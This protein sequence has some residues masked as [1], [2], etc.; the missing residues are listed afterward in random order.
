MK[1]IILSIVILIVS[2]G[3]SQ[4]AEIKEKFID[5]FTLR[6]SFQSKNDKAEPALITYTKPKDKEASWLLNAAIGYDLL[7]KTELILIINPYFEYHKNTLVDKEQ[8]NW[9]TGIS[10][11]WQ[12]IRDFSKYNWSPIIISSVKYNEDKIKNLKSFQGNIYFTPIFKGKDLNPS[13]FWL[14]NTTVNFGSILQFVYSPYVGFENEN[15]IKNSSAN[16]VGNIYR[17]YLRLSSSIMLFPKDENLKDKFEF[18][19]DWQYR[20]D[21]SESVIELTNKEHRFFTTGFNYTFFSSNEGKKTAKVGFDYTN[22]ENPT[23]GFEKQ[24]YYSINLKVKL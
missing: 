16:S 8:E 22:G 13:F 5:R 1:R 20:Y 18:N 15:R 23:K 24:S 21:F 9:Q 19:V 4:E 3:Y 12:I 11:E 17:G 10:A 6:Q 2:K 7:K 14:P